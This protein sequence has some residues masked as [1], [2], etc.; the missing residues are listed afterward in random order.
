MKWCVMKSHQTI[1]KAQVLFQTRAS[2][3]EGAK[4]SL[5]LPGHSGKESKFSKK[6]L[7]SATHFHLIF[8]SV[9]ITADCRTGITLI[10]HKNQV[11][12]SGIMT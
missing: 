11:H 2:A 6:K 4:R 9:A 10:L 3:R 1:E 7:K 8:L 5:A 12:S